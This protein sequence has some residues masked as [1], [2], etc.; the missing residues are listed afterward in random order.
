MIAEFTDIAVTSPGIGTGLNPQH[1]NPLYDRSHF[2][3]SHLIALLF[4][5]TNSTNRLFPGK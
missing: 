5:L 4:A 3:G 1:N 2:S